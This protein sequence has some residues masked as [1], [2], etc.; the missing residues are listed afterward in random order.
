MKG[1]GIKF[2][3]KLS[4]K[5]NKGISDLVGIFIVLGIFSIADC[6]YAGMDPDLYHEFMVKV[7]EVFIV[8]FILTILIEIPILYA[9]LKNIAKIKWIALSGLIVN[10]ITLPILWLLSTQVVLHKDDV[11][12]IGFIEDL[13]EFFSQASL[14]IILEF[15]FLW[16][17][18]RLLFKF[19]KTVEKLSAR[20]AFLV[21]LSANLLFLILGCIFGSIFRNFF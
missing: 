11:Y 18:F 2:M 6:V 7:P 19:G 9:F 17:I 21:S 20:K 14:G 5:L 12:N 4:N 8:A 10:V 16:L 15:L 3:F 1:G 13:S